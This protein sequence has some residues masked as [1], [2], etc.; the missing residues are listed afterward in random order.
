MGFIA[1]VEQLVPTGLRRPVRKYLDDRAWRRQQPP[2]KFDNANL[3]RVSDFDIASAM[4]DPLIGAAFA[5]DLAGIAGVFGAD[6]IAGGVNPGDR[7]ALYHLI[8]HFKLRRILEIGTHVGASTIHIASA[9]RRFV[10]QGSLCTA[11]ISDVNGPGGAWRSS[12]MRQPPSG[13]MSDLGLAPIVSFVVKPAVAVLAPSSRRFDMIFLDGDHAES[14]V[15]REISAALPVLNPNGLI[16]LHD[17][18]P[19][20]MPLVPDGNVEF[21]PAAA[22][23]RI[24]KETDALA[25]LPLGNLP[26]P[27]KNGGNATSLALIS[28]R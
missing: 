7:R 10:D 28:K 15:Y 11:D 2:L 18:Y 24:E 1:S 6:E 12:G 8:G 25:F 22:A 26:W 9:L 19:D 23:S 5:E 14:A 16:L 13:I 17:F 3:R 27:T 20:G 4:N 21:G